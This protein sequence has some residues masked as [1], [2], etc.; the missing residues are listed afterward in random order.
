MKEFIDLQL[1]PREW[2]VL[3]VKEWN[4]SVV[5]VLTRFQVEKLLL[6]SREALW[7]IPAESAENELSIE[8]YVEMLDFLERIN[9]NAYRIILRE[10]DSGRLVKI[11]RAL[12]HSWKQHINEKFFINMSQRAW[13]MLRDEM[14]SKIPLMNKYLEEAISHFLDV[15]HR[16]E[17]EGQ[18]VIPKPGEK[19][20]D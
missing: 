14:E 10:V 8:Q 7:K 2:F 3:T 12:E 15:A 5:K 11:L 6:Q 9:D 1:D 17:M 18:I 16:L 19:Y 20:I 13:N 4:V